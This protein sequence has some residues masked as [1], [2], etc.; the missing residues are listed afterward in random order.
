MQF[1]AAHGGESGHVVAAVYHVFGVGDVVQPAEYSQVAVYA[2]RCLEVEHYIALIINGR[3]YIKAADTAHFGADIE[4]SEGVPV[5]PDKILVLRRSGKVVQRGVQVRIGSVEHQSFNG[6][7]SQ[8]NLHT[9]V[10]KVA[11]VDV[12][13]LHDLNHV[14]ALAEICGDGCFDNT[15]EAPCQRQFVIPHFLRLE[16]WICHSI[17]I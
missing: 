7:A 5:S 1:Y 4:V 13:L 14:R 16:V 17:K 8:S 9:L 11:G 2:V 6:V 3:G 10:D 12:L 15:T